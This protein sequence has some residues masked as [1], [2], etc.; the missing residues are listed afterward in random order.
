MRFG[1]CCGPGDAVFAKSAGFDY[2]EWNVGGLLMPLADD[3]AFEAALAHAKAVALPCEALNVMVPGDLKITG[4]DANPAKLEAYAKTMCGR[5]KRAGIRRIVFGSGA[6]RAVPA[7]FPMEKARGQIAAFLKMLAPFARD[8]GVV[9]VVEPLNKGET[10]IINSVAEGAEIVREVNDPNIRLLADAYHMQVDNE[11]M[12]NLTRH[13]GLIAHAH[14]ASREGRMPPGVVPCAAVQE[15]LTRLRDAGYD[16]RVS[17][18]GAG[19][20]AANARVA[21]ATMCVWT[22]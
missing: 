11:P 1:Y 4:P 9:I 19:F 5:A 14:V 12:E 6:A 8:A 17:V 2:Y 15:F 13:I 22:N 10:N 18:E 3:A 16:G 21:R 7:G 20:S